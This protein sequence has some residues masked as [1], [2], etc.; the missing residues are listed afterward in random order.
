METFTDFTDISNF[1]KKNRFNCLEI[2]GPTLLFGDN[3]PYTIYN[4]FNEIDNLNLYDLK[5]SFISIKTSNENRMYNTIY[6]DRS[7]IDKKYDIVISSHVLEHMA[8]P[9]KNLNSYKN[10]L[11]DNTNSYILTILPNKSQFWDSI[12]PTTEITHIIND[13]INNVYEDDKT[14]EEENLSV[15][16]PYKTSI[17]HPDKPANISYE[18]M[19]KNN[20]NYRIMHHHCFDLQ[21]CIQLHEYSNFETIV[22]FIPPND[23]LQIIYFG[24]SA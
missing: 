20:S 16:H 9:I 12:R 13:F 3:Y 10:L 23:P 24:R 6:S 1:I 11:N 4:S 22:C 7:H 21:L 19:V 18:D 2:G 15:N 14:H 17:D 5:D 8:N